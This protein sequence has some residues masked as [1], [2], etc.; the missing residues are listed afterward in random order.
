MKSLST[1]TG[2][3]LLISSVLG[4]MDVNVASSADKKSSPQ[5]Q[6]KQVAPAKGPSQ[7]QIENWVE[8]ANL[9]AAQRTFDRSLSSVGLWLNIMAV[10]LTF[11]TLILA[12][13][14]VAAAFFANRKYKSW[15][16]VF[17]EAKKQADG[18]KQDK[19]DSGKVL[20]DLRNSI[21][22]IHLEAVLKE[23]RDDLTPE[24]LLAFRE[25]P[26][27]EFLR[28]LKDFNRKLDVVEILAGT[29]TP[30]DYVLRAAYYYY[31][32][33]DPEA[34]LQ[35]LNSV[36]EK[37]PDIPGIWN[38]IA[39]I[40]LSLDRKE[41]AL[42]AVERALDK[43][44]TDAEAWRTK[45]AI[46]SDLGRHEDALKAINSALETQPDSPTALFLKGSV[47]W[48]LNR[49]EEAL[50]AFDRT[51]ELKPDNTAAWHNKGIALGNLGRH[52]E[53][54][55]A[56][57][58]VIE[59]QPNNAAAWSNK[60]VALANFNRHE[61]ALAAFDKALELKPDNSDNWLKKGIALENLN[62]HEEALAS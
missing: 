18:I 11:L 51:L 54:L 57:S 38:N 42:K 41:D 17:D 53:A 31:G 49:P 61:E 33:T 32:D 56:F 10:L 12:G 7:E 1:V 34:A 58:R 26:T 50:A 59:L 25:K 3:V 47:L 23:T 40:Y 35:L 13:L 52:E 43:S 22:P 48:Y 44:G 37:N 16:E 60:G 19:L 46:L 20:T 21:G 6:I 39:V 8:A 36:A 5:V 15:K 55:A 45:A 14:S 62:R 30:Q 28:K 4:G 27:R 2:I 29:V 24:G 9:K